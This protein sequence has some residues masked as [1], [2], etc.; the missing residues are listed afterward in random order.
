MPQTLFLQICPPVHSLL[1][2]Q[3]QSPLVRHDGP[4]LLEAQSTQ[5]PPVLPHT[6]LA[7]P[8]AHWPPLQQPSKQAPQSALRLRP[9]LSV[10]V[11]G[12]QALPRRRQK[13]GSDSL[14]ALLTPLDATQVPRLQIWSE[15]QGGE[16]TAA[17]DSQTPAALQLSPGSQSRLASQGTLQREAIQ[18]SPPAQSEVRAQWVFHE[19]FLAQAK[20]ET[21]A[22][23]R[24]T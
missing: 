4:A 6:A 19:A 24:P 9:H 10:A 14:Q 23:P 1:P 3:P 13:A 12:P 5:A 20:V 15:G 22:S 7:V 16:Q 17:L 21:K 18:R 8:A 11:S 2:V